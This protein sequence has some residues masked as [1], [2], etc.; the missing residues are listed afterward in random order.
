MIVWMGWFVLS[1][2]LMACIGMRRYSVSSRLMSIFVEIPI[3]EVKTLEMM[4]IIFEVFLFFSDVTMKYNIFTLIVCILLFPSQFILI[5]IAGKATSQ[6]N[7]L[8]CR[9]RL[10]S[11]KKWA[12]R[13][14]A[15]EFM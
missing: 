5:R 4:C 2:I 8:I 14:R 7:L 10:A 1:M 11:I 9:R 13:R 12:R 3:E 15:Y 6:I